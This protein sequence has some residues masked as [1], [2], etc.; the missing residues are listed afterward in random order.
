MHEHKKPQN[1]YA[2]SLIVGFLVFLFHSY[3]D[4]PLRGGMREPSIYSGLYATFSLCAIHLSNSP[5]LELVI[6]QIIHLARYCSNHYLSGYSFSRLSVPQT[7]I[8]RLGLPWDGA[9][10]MRID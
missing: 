6:F 5:S 1:T 10:G 2:Q 9:L 8:S 7:V 4:P 3:T